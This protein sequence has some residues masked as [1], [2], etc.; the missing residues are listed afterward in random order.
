MRKPDLY[1]RGWAIVLFLLF[2]FHVSPAQDLS[3]YLPDSVTYNPAIPKPA[4]IIYHEPGEWHVT[5]DR[6]INYMQAIAKAAPGRVKLEVIGFTYET[7]PQVLLI[8]TSPQ[9]HQ[10]LEEIRQQHLQL[11]DPTKSAALDITHMPIV[12]YIGHSIH[13]NES[14]GAN[15]ALVSAYYLAAAQGKQIDELLENTVILFD[16]SFNPDGLQRFSTWVNQHK[17]KN[18]VTDPDSREFNEVWPGGRGNHYWFDLN[19]DWLTGVHVESRNRLQWFYKWRPNI[20]T[21]HHEQGSNSSFFFQPGVPS[22]VNPLTPAYNQELTGKLAQFHAAFLD[23]IGSFYFTK[24]NYDDF[25][26]GKG[27]SFPDING[28]VGILFEQASSR[29]HAQ[30]TENGILRFPF[31]IKNQFTTTLSTLEG[32]KTLRKEFLTYQR[33]F[34]K[35]VATEAATAPVKGYVFGSPHD[36]SK[37]A[38]FIDML[39]RQQ[40]AVYELSTPLQADGYSFEK[41]SSYVVPANQTQ[42]KLIRAIF[43]K[44]LSYKDSLFYDVTAWTLPLAFGLPYAE[45]NAPRFTNTLLGSQVDKTVATTGTVAGGKSNYAYLFEWDEYYAPRALYALQEAGINTRASAGIFEIPVNSG[46]HKFNYGTICIPVKTQTLDA[47]K[48]YELVKTTMEQNGIT[49]YAL[50]TG[51]ATNGSDLGSWKMRPVPQP[52]IAM[53]TGNGVNPT[54]AG[55][56]WFLLDQQFNIPSTHLEVSAFNRCDL[57]KYNTLIMV[58]ATYGAP[59]NTIDKDKLRTWV[60]AGGTLLVMEEAVQWAAQNGFTNIT[61]RKAKEDTAKQVTYAER[62]YRLGAQKMNGAIFRAAV[63]LSHPL[64]YGYR[65]PFVDLFKANAIFPERNK[66]PYSTPLVYGD[67]PLQSGFVTKEN[68]EAVKNSAAVLVN[69]LGSG[70][71]ISIAD[72]PN[73]RAFWL[74]STKLFMNAIFFGRIVEPG[75]ARND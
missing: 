11:S 29:G 16:P 63:D 19:R 12:L 62:D 42:Y 35:N 54:D 9:N 27:S 8:I 6:L 7:R 1:S 4:S 32:A 18:L 23:R 45:L 72:N 39:R 5:H 40:I 37:T 53:I 20:L 70:R 3:Y 2:I 15:A 58:G 73:F 10:R 30:K 28:A 57:T 69:T 56:V 25:Y 71:V 60:Q 50:Q 21:D 17:S 48:L 41:G 64:A 14:S 33:D 24:E 74:S 51:N 66:N 38:L 22:R 47:D 36:K 31:T 46:T 34:Y 13:G 75:S 26:Y 65:Y 55:E 44:T 68:Y 59:Y 49:A 52:S 43:D 67:K 61:F